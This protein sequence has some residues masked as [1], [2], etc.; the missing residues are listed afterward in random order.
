[1]KSS[2]WKKTPIKIVHKEPTS[3][4]IHKGTPNEYVFDPVVN[5]YIPLAEFYRRFEVKTGIKNGYA[6]FGTI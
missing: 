6:P 2:Y 4:D 1:M 3:E 5:D